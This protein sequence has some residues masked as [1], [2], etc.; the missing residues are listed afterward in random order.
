MWRYWGLFVLGAVLTLG[1][2]AS[3]VAVAQD[4][5]AGI[6]VG[7]VI[8]GPDGL[9]RTYCVQLSTPNP[10]GLDALIATGATLALEQGTL[11]TAVCA[12][13][14]I[15]CV[16]PEESCF[17]Q[18]EGGA[19]CAYWAYFQQTPQGNWQYSPFGAQATR[20]TAG[21]VEGWWWRDNA[22]A[23]LS[24]PSVSFAD[25]C[26]DAIGF[27]RIVR[28]DLGREV[29]I[30]APPQ[31]IASVTLASDEILLELVGP[32]RLLGVTYMAADPTLSPIADRLEGVR[33]TD[34]TGN[35]ELLIGLDA[36]LLI[37]ST[38]NNPAALDQLIAAGMPL[39]VMGG[40]SSFD[41]IRDNIRLLGEVTGEERQAETLIAQM[42]A[43][44]A[45]VRVRVA[46][47]P[48]VRVLYYELG[49]ISYGPGSTVDEVIRL[50]GG[51][52]VIAEAGLGPYPLINPEFI[53]AADPDMILLGAGFAASGNPLEAFA[54]DPVF[55][56]LK[57]VQSGRVYHVDDA[58]LT[59]V[60]HYL[61]RSVEYV[62][63][64]LHPEA[65]EGS[66][67][68]GAPSE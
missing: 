47:Q 45:D 14:G 35:P 3:P 9:S 15:G 36:D 52:N 7:V 57:A 24:L 22:Q 18:C 68:S 55:S 59:S 16:P 4:D 64:L 53:L 43:I 17:C 42:D 67:G 21:G 62:A 41:D 60:S 27:P 19:S 31:R 33:R 8:Q 38:Y 51:T 5:P 48:P 1:V 10:T 11:G 37:L 56:T 50:A 46:E 6:R 28:D 40:F 58:Y 65:F 29:V 44:L 30:E 25:L 49:G 34:L 12:I 2:P 54:N 23:S 13:E 66:A 61:A 39:V 63:H 32:E 20:V 26:G